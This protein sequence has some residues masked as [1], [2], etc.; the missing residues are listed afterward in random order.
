MKVRP[1]YTRIAAALFCFSA[2]FGVA[3]LA[4]ILTVKAI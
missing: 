4:L 3:Y 2:W 1:N